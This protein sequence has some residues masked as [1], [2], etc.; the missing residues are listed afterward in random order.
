MGWATVGL[1]EPGTPAAPVGHSDRVTR[2]LVIGADAAGMAAAHQALRSARQHRR[3]LDVIALEMTE[4]TSYS[5]C[6]IPYWIAGDVAGEDA[7]VART[8]QG[9]RDRG[10]DLRMRHEAVGLDLAA[11]QVHVRDHEGGRDLTLGYDDLL[12]ATGA[13]PVIPDWALVDGAL[14]PGVGAVKTLDDGAAWRRVLVDQPPTAV[15]VGGGYIGV[16]VAESFARRGVRTTLVT[17]RTPMAASLVPEQTAHVQRGLEEIGVQVC[18]GSPVV[19]LEGRKDGYAVITADGTEHFGT[20]V[21]LAI[22]V[23]PRVELGDGQLPVTDD[24]HPWARGAFAPDPTQRLDG[25]VWAAGD[26]CAVHDLV[27]DELNYLPLGT[28]A[29][30]AGRV[31]GINL[32][33]G[34]ARF[35]GAVGT[36]ITRSGHVEVARAGLTPDWAD[37]LGLEYVTASLD[38]TTASGYM[39]EA[40]PMTLWG[41]AERGTGR[42]LGAQLTG[43]PGAGKRID[44]L[45]TALATRMSAHD[46]AYLDLAYAPPFSPTWDPVQILCRKLADLA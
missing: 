27:L 18:T 7:L 21:A 1:P 24:A 46:V 6:G 39:P 9:H 19:G 12:I 5:Q 30:K 25:N 36:A 8:V 11:G 14:P 13:A 40:S 4:H 28:H 20:V 23:A 35:P 41:I 32:G 44:V 22:G 29:N 3:D 34:Q 15:V 42:L 43:G 16:E 45:A 38:S 37:R 31:A 2:L 10:V 26:N 33:G 17:R